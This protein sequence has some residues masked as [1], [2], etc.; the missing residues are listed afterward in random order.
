MSVTT[1]EFDL[2]ISIILDMLKA[3]QVDRVIE[4][5]EETKSNPNK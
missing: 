5:L 3:G 2:L 1:K 4:L